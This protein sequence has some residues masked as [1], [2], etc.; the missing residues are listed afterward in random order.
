M[1]GLFNKVS[2]SLEKG[3]GKIGQEL[4]KH[5]STIKFSESYS[6]PRM[7]DPK[8][9]NKNQQPQ[10]YQNQPQNYQNP[11]PQHY[12]NY[13]QNYQ[14]PN[15]NFQNP[16]PQYYQNQPHYYQNPPT[17]YQNP[18]PLNSENQSLYPTL[19]INIPP[20]KTSQS[21]DEHLSYVK[22]EKDQAPKK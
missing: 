12:Q 22:V 4:N 19:D 2:A 3:F 1:E 21:K 16:Q 11:P 15:Q 10:N 5:Q 9:K 20:P 7:V 6:L 18:P 13:P 8:E 17:N 14:N